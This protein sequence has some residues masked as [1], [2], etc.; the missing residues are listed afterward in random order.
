MN[1]VLKK[2]HLQNF[3]SF[4]PDVATLDLLPLNV[5]VGPNGAGKS[6][7]LEAIRFLPSAAKGL[8]VP[9]REGGGVLDWIH[10]SN[11]GS[12]ATIGVRM[13]NTPFNADRFGCNLEY[14]LSFAGVH[15]RFE[16]VGESLTSDRPL[17]EGETRNALYYDHNAR[18]TIINVL[19]DAE[20]GVPPRE[21]IRKIRRLERETIESNASILSQRRDPVS[22]PEL[23]HVADVFSKIRVYRDWRFGGANPVRQTQPADADTDSLDEDFANAAIF[24]NRLRDDRKAKSRLMEVVSTLY[25]GFEDVDARVEGGRA[26]LRVTEKNLE[27]SIPA[28]RLSDGT[29][30]FICLAALLV[31][32]TLPPVIC[33]DEPELGMHP[34]MIHALA[35]L[36]KDAST[37]TQIL[38][39]THSVQMLDALSDMPE[40]IVVCEK[41]GGQSTLRRL[42]Q[43]DMAVWLNK[44]SLGKLW[45]DGILGGNRW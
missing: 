21:G 20:G 10:Q 33:L 26:I 19:T 8:S 4:G 15:N 30:R 42:S 23:T 34:D 22:Y 41:E 39:T 13:A 3:L 18:Q 9:V 12:T 1:P 24:L 2:I 17:K 5:F 43:D 38:I 29:L 36:L 44:Y 45:R 32:P 28:N 25:D 16:V 37:H 27:K 7:L 31:A 6:N 11:P 14:S 40:A 35:Q